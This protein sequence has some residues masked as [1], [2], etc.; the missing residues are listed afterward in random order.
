[1]H[2]R[3]EKEKNKS[4]TVLAPLQK[5]AIE[6]TDKAQRVSSARLE[7]SNTL[8]NTKPIGA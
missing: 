8:E 4:G 6:D 5:E 7:Q 2:E 1:V 3:K